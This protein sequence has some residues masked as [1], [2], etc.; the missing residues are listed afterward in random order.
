MDN[1]ISSDDK[2]VNHLDRNVDSEKATSDS[3][4]AIDA[5]VAAASPRNVHGVAVSV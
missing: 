4:G 2:G 5:P 1:N 3:S